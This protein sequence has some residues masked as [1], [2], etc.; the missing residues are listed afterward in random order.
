MEDFPLNGIFKI[1]EHMASLEE[2]LGCIE[3]IEIMLRALNVTIL[4]LQ[5]QTIHLPTIVQ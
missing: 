4:V 2:D 5:L 3:P 1:R